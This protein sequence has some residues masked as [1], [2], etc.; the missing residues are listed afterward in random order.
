MWTWQ[1]GSMQV[2]QTLCIFWL[3]QLISLTCQIFDCF[4]YHFNDIQNTGL[5]DIIVLE[6]ICSVIY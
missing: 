2:L 6:P 4:V 3:N 5:T 1:L